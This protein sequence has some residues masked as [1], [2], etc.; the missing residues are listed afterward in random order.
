M[1]PAMI[2]HVQYSLPHRVRRKTLVD[3]P[4]QRIL[5]QHSACTDQCTCTTVTPGITRAPNATH[6][7]SSMT[8]GLTISPKCGSR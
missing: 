3:G 2:R 7:P 4:W 1:G 5:G 8:I 6:A